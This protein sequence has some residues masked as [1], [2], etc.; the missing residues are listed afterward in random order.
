MYTAIYVQN[1]AA[2]RGAVLIALVAVRA[3]AYS[4]VSWKFNSDL[5]AFFKGQIV[6]LHHYF[7][8]GRLKTI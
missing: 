7:F 8:E 4:P 2:P 3:L 1:N 5:F 6:F